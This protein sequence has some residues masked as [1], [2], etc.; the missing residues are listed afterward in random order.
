M[1]AKL[2]VPEGPGPV[3]NVDR[4]VQLDAN[5]QVVNTFDVRGVLLLQNF[6]GK[7]TLVNIRQGAQQ[8]Q[9]VQ[10]K[11]R[12]SLTWCLFSSLCGFLVALSTM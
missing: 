8:K 2:I 1:N 10:V 4:I 9:P 12:A 6:E 3:R 11:S 5:C 7:N